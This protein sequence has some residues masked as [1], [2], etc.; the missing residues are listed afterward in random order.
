LLT[1]VSENQRYFKNYKILVDTNNSEAELMS[2]SIIDEQVGASLINTTNNTVNIWTKNNTNLNALTSVFDVS[3]N[4]GMY[5]KSVTQRNGITV[6]NF[7]SPVTYTIVSE[8]ETNWSDWIVQVS[9]DTIKPELTLLGDSV[10]TINKGDA[11]TDPGATA[12]DN[13]NGDISLSIEVLGIVD[14]EEI[15]SYLIT[16]KASDEAGNTS[17]ITRNV[18]VEKTTGI[19]NRNLIEVGIFAINKTIYINVPAAMEGADVS[20]YNINGS[21]VY[22]S[23]KIN[24]GMNT[25]QTKLLQ[26][27]YLVRLVKKEQFYSGKV[28]IN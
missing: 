14:T 28:I 22:Q 26:G 4:A 8:D 12:F 7:V 2:F 3:D 6:N 1:V 21:K 16:Y 5:V 19:N 24:S 20:I 9:I 13:V 10:V 27:L 17:T 15:G 25:I 11:F 23:S 18:I